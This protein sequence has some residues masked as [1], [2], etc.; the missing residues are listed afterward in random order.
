MNK[1][2][3]LKADQQIREDDLID[4]AIETV[5]LLRKIEIGIQQADAGELV[6]HEEVEARFLP[7]KTVARLPE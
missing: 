4:Q 1:Q 2:T 5:D 6:S 7:T 3:R